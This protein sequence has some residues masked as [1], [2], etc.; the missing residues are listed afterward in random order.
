LV[1]DDGMN[2]VEIVDLDLSATSQYL[3]PA[4]LYQ[5]ACQSFGGFRFNGVWYDSK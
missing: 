5:P 4:A 2:L 1:G 3:N